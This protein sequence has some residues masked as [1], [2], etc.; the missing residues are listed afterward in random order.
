MGPRRLL[1]SLILASAACA[2]A[3]A[4]QIAAVQSSAGPVDHTRVIQA[5]KTQAVP[6]LDGSLDSPL[7]AAGVTAQGF[8]NFSLRRPAKYATV[9]YLLYDDKNFYVGVHAEQAGTPIIATQ[10]VDH[11]G[12]VNDDHILLQIDTS[13]NGSRVYTFRASPR[14][15]HDESSSENA[16]YAPEWTS[17]GKIFANGDYNVVMVIPLAD[18]RAQNAPVQRWRINVARL[19]AA[20]SDAYTWAYEPNETDLHNPAFW[21][22]FDGIKIA[23]SATR[24]KPHAEIYAL[25]SSGTDRRRFQDGFGRFVSTNPRG[26]GIDFTY[27]VTNTLAV[28]GT[29]NPDFSNVETDQTSIAPQTFERNYTEYRPFFAQ[30]A[31]YINALPEINMNGIVETLFYTPSIGIFDRGVKVEGTAGNSS[32]GALNVRGADFNDTALGYSYRTPDHSATMSAQGVLANHGGIRDASYGVGFQGLNAHSGIFEI[33]K[34]E[35]EKKTGADGSHYVFASTG[36]QTASWFLALDYRDIAPGFAP[37]DGYTAIDDIRGPRLGFNYNGVGAKGGF[38]KSWTVGGMV[39]RFVDRT[40]A[41]KEYDENGS[42]GITFDNQLT[43]SGGAGTSG[44]RFDPSSAAPLVRYDLQQVGLGY[45]DGTP[46]PVDLTYAFGPFGGA[47]L[48]QLDFSTSRALGEYAIS[49]E[50]GGTAERGGEA[51]GGHDSQWIRRFSLSR[52]FGRNTS[53]A[54][55]LRSINGYGGYARP[56][57]NLAFSF[58]RRL[59]NLDEIYVDYGTPAAPSTLHRA[60]AKYVFHLGAGSGT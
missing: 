55:G 16:R 58:H 3:H 50:Y 44:I 9:A 18:M 26:T 4:D 27:P 43:F 52:S 32:V 31:R 25:G 5:V 46:S 1:L 40:G 23:S 57:A 7:W 14:G 33:I 20:T 12:V 45:R 17:V 36:F 13:G 28:V 22:A 8:E 39:D 48:Q 51:P 10:N 35:K 30:G 60:V 59:R 21:P 19:V 2:A 24:P 37:V 41:P 49:L 38:I 29:V 47:Y 34:A 56:G 15:I 54:I 11:A 53:L 6:P 42:F